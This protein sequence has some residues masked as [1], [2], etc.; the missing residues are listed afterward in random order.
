MTSTEQGLT[1]TLY[2]KHTMEQ[3]E[4]IFYVCN[5]S[6]INSQKIMPLITLFSSNT[7]NRE[8]FISVP[9]SEWFTYEKLQ[10]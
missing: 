6:D 10:Q 3:S 9:H 2:W 1:L 8:Y 7:V 4:N 5:Y